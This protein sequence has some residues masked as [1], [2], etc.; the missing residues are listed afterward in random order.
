MSCRLLG[1]LTFF[2]FFFSTV[3]LN[4]NFPAKGREGRKKESDLSGKLSLK[5]EDSIFL[6]MLFY[7]CEKLQRI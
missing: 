3:E 6:Q 5:E 2:L 7:K 1:T 4:E